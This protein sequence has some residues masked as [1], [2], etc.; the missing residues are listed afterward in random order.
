M[1]ILMLANLRSVHAQRWAAGLATRGHTVAAASIRSAELQNVGCHVVRW[2]PRDADRTYRA[3]LDYG[4]LAAKLKKIVADFRPDVINAHYALTNGLL[5]S[6]LR[7]RPLAINVWGSDV[8]WDK[9]QTM[10]WH[11][12]KWAQLSL[13][14]ASHVISTSEFMLKQTIEL[15]KYPTPTSIVPFGVDT[16]QFRP[17]SRPAR[18]TFTVGWVKT[19]SWKY[20]PDTFVRAAAKAARRDPS[21]R[22][23]MAGRGPELDATKSLASSLGIG[24]RIQFP[25]F[26]DHRVLPSLLQNFDLLVN[27]SRGASETFGVIILEASA[28]G[29]PVIAT[30]VGGV[31]EAMIP[32]QTALLVPADR[33]DSMA[34]AILSLR[35]NTPQRLLMGEA[36]RHLAEARFQ[37]SECVLLQEQALRTAMRQGLS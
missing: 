1:R 16:K 4:L 7:L 31:R 23:V 10:P 30:D 32:G 14:G 25:G 27:S 21:L 17:I 28:S 13:S 24:E 8:V 18:G 6:A 26:V 15:M 9:A 5:A 35:E 12:R 34:E 20:A 36:G 2:G 19:F 3:L 29:L 37:W 11:R 22:F 33:P